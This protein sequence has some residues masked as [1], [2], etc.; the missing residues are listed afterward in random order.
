[1]VYASVLDRAGRPVTEVAA[2]D[3][4]VRENNTEADPSSFN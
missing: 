4:A 1:M 3:F 2:K